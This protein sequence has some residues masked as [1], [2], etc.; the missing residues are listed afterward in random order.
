MIH[1]F[2]SV[3]NRPDFVSIQNQLF[4]KF[5]KNDYKFHIVDDSVDSTIAKQFE[6]ICSL[7]QL[8]YYKTPKK[9]EHSNPS[10]KVGN[11]IQWVFDEII[12]KNYSSDIVFWLDSDMFLIDEFDIEDYVSDCVIA[13]L[14]QVRGHIKYMWNGIMFFNM[15]KLMA[16][17]PNI[18]FN[19]DNIDGYELDTGGETYHYFKKNNIDMKPTNDGRPIYPTHYNEIDLQKD[20]AGYNMELHLDNKFLH[21]RAATNWHSN[22]RGFEDPL[23]GKTQVFNQVIESVLSE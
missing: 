12:K 21:Y 16:L 19:I 15:P 10:T 13:G 9:L 8:E 23:I 22:W 3:V 14:P 20:A 7:N 5:L 1:I 6:T 18:K 11:V 17:D 2:T 4:K